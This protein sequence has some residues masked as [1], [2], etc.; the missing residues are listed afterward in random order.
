MTSPTT[1]V[2][3]AIG[4]AP[5]L[6][7]TPINLLLEIIGEPGTG[8]THLASILPKPFL[9]DTSPKGEA[10]TTFIRLVKDEGRYAHVGNWDE[11]I[12]A[13]KK[14]G[15]RFDVKTVI[16]DTS[17]DLQ[18]M[19]RAEYM[20]IHGRKGVLQIEFGF[21]RDLVDAQIVYK[22]TASPPTG[23]GKNVVCT[24]QMKDLYKTIQDSEGK[25]HSFKEGRQRD[26]YQRLDFQADVRLFLQLKE[27]KVGEVMKTRRICT[28][29]KNRFIDKASDEWI[30][31]V[32]PISWESIR[33][34]VKLAPGEVVLE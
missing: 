24:S 15:A 18:D 31:D 3:G 13:T 14:A 26:G 1:Q 11:L 29:I 22:L 28:V 21:V 20:R 27:D 33:K 23:Y 2:E 19:A 16:L 5:S 9:I 10:R 6:P 30:S 34:L 17:A 7:P 25:A 8:K 32:N 4:G 12:S